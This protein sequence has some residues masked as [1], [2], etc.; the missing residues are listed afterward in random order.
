MTGPLIDVATLARRLGESGTVVVDCRFSLTAPEAGRQ[1]YLAGHIPG[2]RYAHLEEDLA[3]APAADEGRHPLPTPAA[4]ARTLGQLGIGNDSDIVVYDDQSGAVAAR[5]WWMLRWVGHSRV[6][7]LDGGLQAW[8]ESGGALAAG[9]GAGSTARD[10]RIT[11]PQADAVATTAEIA[12]LDHAAWQLVD[13]RSAARFAGRE[14]PIDPVAGH[15]PGARS[16]PFS[17]N[18]AADRRLRSPRE[19]AA[20]LERLGLAPQ[21]GLIAMCGSGVTA[22]HLLLALAVLG[23]DGRLYTGSWS[24]WIRDPGRPV[25]TE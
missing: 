14:E 15:V 8:V 5:L 11:T 10:Y 16:W 7:V 25:A 13:A 18:V 22:C 19:L 21:T 9:P 24:E 17:D 2:A 1:A 12:T 20:N 4:F 3:R 23:R 6:A